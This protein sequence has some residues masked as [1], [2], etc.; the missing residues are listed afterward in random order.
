MECD[1]VVEGDTEEEVLDRAA[2]HGRTEHGMNEPPSPEI[3]RGVEEQDR[4]PP[5]RGRGAWFPFGRQC[6]RHQFEN[7][8]GAGT[9]L[10]GEIPQ[11]FPLE[12]AVSA[13]RLYC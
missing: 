10:E 2:E 8:G 5:L 3:A 9:S 11:R 13:D 4:S 6:P 12:L 1:H 7:P